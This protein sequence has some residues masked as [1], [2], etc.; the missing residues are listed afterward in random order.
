MCRTSRPAVIVCPAVSTFRHNSLEKLD[1]QGVNRGP[2]PAAGGMAMSLLR[3]FLSLSF[4]WTLAAACSPPSAPSALPRRSLS[5]AQYAEDE[6]VHVYVTS[7]VTDPPCPT[8]GA[9][10]QGT[11]NGVPLAVESRGGIETVQTFGS[12]RQRCRGAELTG[13]APG[14]GAVSIRIWDSRETLEADF[15]ELFSTRTIELIEPADK[16][17][18][19]GD[20][21]RLRRWPPG[22]QLEAIN[23][24]QLLQEVPVD[25]KSWRVEGAL[26]GDDVVFVVP[27]AEFYV[28]GESSLLLFDGRIRTAASSCRGAETCIG[29]PAG[30]V[31]P[32]APVTILNRP[33]SGYQPCYW[34]ACTCLDG[35]SQAEGRSTPPASR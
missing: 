20:H 18:Y 11:V 6:P 10:L 5:V 31:Q 27:E 34:C 19:V 28:E 9:E 13:Q 12:A 30:R 24:Q 29:F 23:N 35:R 1:L 26:E 4:V 2:P 3:P 32:T 22:E 14:P 7:S 17:L 25:S 33:R 8:L 15:A 21:A 16:T